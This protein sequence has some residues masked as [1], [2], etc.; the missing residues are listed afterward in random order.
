MALTSPPGWPPGP[1]P[2]TGGA[3]RRLAGPGAIVAVA[4]VAAVVVH[5]RPPVDGAYPSCPLHALTGLW[6]PLCGATRMAAAVMDGHLATALHDNALV[7]LL[8][9]PLAVVGLVSWSADLLA[10]R[11]RRAVLGR[12]GWVVVVVAAVAFTVVRNLA[13]GHALAP[14]ALSGR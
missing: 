2:V 8:L 3:A 11:P 4:G 7:L 10:G 14:L 9:G 5:L 13:V 12:R 1:P 6:C